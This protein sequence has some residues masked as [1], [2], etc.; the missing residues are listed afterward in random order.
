M[1]LTLDEQGGRLRCRPCGQQWLLTP[2]VPV[3]E[4]MQL[5]VAAHRCVPVRSAPSATTRSVGA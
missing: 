5:L 2:D 1:T 4:Q 3:T